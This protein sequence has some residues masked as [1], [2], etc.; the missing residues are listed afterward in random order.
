MSVCSMG[1]IPG[2]YVTNHVYTWVDPQGRS[3][4]PPPDL[5]D[6]PGSGGRHL[7]IQQ[8]GHLQHGDAEKKVSVCHLVQ[9]IIF[10]LY[11]RTIWSPQSIK[12][13]THTFWTEVTKSSLFAWRFYFNTVHITLEFLYIFYLLMLKTAYLLFSCISTNFCLFL[14]L[15]LGF[16]PPLVIRSSFN[17]AGAV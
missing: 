3:V 13:C 17:T 8:H 14:L 11:N 10:C 2:G 16:L 5:Q 1:R 4:S 15:L 9:V 12:T 6:Q 7:D